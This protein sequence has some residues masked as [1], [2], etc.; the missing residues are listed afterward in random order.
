[1]LIEISKDAKMTIGAKGKL[2]FDKGFYVYTGSAMKG[3]EARVA[4]HKRKDKKLRW[5]IDYLLNHPSARIIEAKLFRS[6]DRQEC[7]LNQQ[8]IGMSGSEIPV[9]GFGSSDCRRC[10]AHLVKA[11]DLAKVRAIIE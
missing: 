5:H 10:P 11:A 2:S 4:R 8:V 7:S 9:V 6:E 3:L 1:M